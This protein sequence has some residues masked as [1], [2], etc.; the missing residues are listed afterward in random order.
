MKTGVTTS[1]IAH[2]ALLIIAIVGLGSAKPL[3]PDVVESIA[4][5]LVPISDITNIRQGSLESTVVKTET[6]AV[7]KTDTPAELAQ[8]AGNTEEDQP[9]PEETDK[10]TPAPVVNTA[11][12]PVEAPQ[13]EPEPDPLPEPPPVPQPVA[14]PDPAPAPEETQPDQQVA[15]DTATDTPPAPVAPVPVLRPAQLQRA[16]AKPMPVEKTAE[17]T[18]KK[19]ETP[20][21]QTEQ[22]RERPNEDAKIADKVAELINSEKSRGATTGKGGDPTLGKTSGRSATLTQS[23][24]DGLVAQIKACMSIPLGAAEAGITAQLH[25]S[26]DAQG[27]VMGR[28]EILSTGQTPLERAL[29]S[30]AQR[31]VMR[32]GPYT[33]APNQEVR[34][35]FDPRELT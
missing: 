34:A 6:P 5:D 21:Q 23:Q 17:I 10:E 27:N 14:A 2:A 7:V 22:A 28:P 24:L 12:K 26:L 15:T 4:V 16:P 13:P 31:A 29:A 20:K 35:T 32:C 25:F 1:V 8:K 33:M 3:E 11:P 18:P 19:T 9:T 30:A